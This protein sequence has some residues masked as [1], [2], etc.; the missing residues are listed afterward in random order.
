MRYLSSVTA[1]IAALA[2]QSAE[3]VSFSCPG[4]REA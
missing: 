1:L 4:G 2:A 3:Y